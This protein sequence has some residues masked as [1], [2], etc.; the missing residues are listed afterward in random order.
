MR[1][2]CWIW[3]ASWSEPA[4]WYC[5]RLSIRGKTSVSEA[6][7]KTRSCEDCAE[8][9]AG[10]SSARARQSGRR[11]ATGARRYQR[12][13]SAVQSCL[14]DAYGG[15]HLVVRASRG[16]SSGRPREQADQEDDA[17]QDEHEEQELRD[18][19]P[20]DHP[21]EEQEQRNHHQQTKHSNTPFAPLHDYNGGGT[22]LDTGRVGVQRVPRRSSW[23]RRSFGSTAPNAS[24][25]SGS[26]CRP[27]WTA[28]SSS[29]F[30]HGYASR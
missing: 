5:G 25:T 4:N 10:R 8:V 11:R 2:P 29:A 12:S 23:I 18:R 27:D 3:N 17:C 28:I 9:A 22:S 24:T 19:D 16:R 6:A 21:E 26:N 30:S 14:G 7:A 13:D 20:P 15:A 1:A